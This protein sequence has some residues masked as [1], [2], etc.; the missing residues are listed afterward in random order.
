MISL[1]EWMQQ[2]KAPTS[3]DVSEACD[4]L[5]KHVLSMGCGSAVI[6]VT[7]EEGG[8]AIVTVKIIDCDPGQYK[9]EGST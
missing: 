7:S 3:K 6:N 9:Q 1:D 2:S 5:I 8:S 4:V